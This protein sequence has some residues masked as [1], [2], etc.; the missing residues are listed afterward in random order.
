MNL[1][2][3]CF[4]SKCDLWNILLGF[5]LSIGFTLFWTWFVFR[6]LYKPRIEIKEVKYLPL[7]VENQ[8]SKKINE[9]IKIKIINIG[10]SNAVNIKIE[11]CVFY[12]TDNSIKTIHF[13]FIEDEFVLLPPKHRLIND[14]RNE[15]VF[16]INRFSDQ[17]LFESEEDLSELSIIGFFESDNDYLRIRVHAS[18]ENSGFGKA[19]EEFFQYDSIN[20]VFTKCIPILINK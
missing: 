9:S 14:D 1:V 13:N 18:L 20:K 12:K 11:A 6:F 8:L 15:R 16:K 19:F 2:L 3:C 10:I 17:A 4:F 7:V 5:V